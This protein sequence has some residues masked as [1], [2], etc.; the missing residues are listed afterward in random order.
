MNIKYYPNDGTVINEYNISK[1]IGN[2][3]NMEEKLNLENKIEMYENIIKDY[4]KK[5]KIK[6]DKQ[7]IK[8]F[9][10]IIFTITNLIIIGKSILLFLNYGLTTN[11]L[12]KSIIILIF[13]I[14]SALNIEEIK[15]EKSI[16]LLT[17][18]LTILK[19]NLNITKE[20]LNNLSLE[21]NLHQD[22]K[23]I[24]LISG[25]I[26]E[27]DIKKEMNDTYKNHYEEIKRTRT[28]NKQ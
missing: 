3:F 20:K 10:I 15:K 19:H 1:N 8:K 12:S 18:E 5:I 4:E 13:T 28:K 11:L 21:K 7:F 27:E 16:V 26:L 23:P 2:S 9:L 25:R 6:K 22:N 17:Q 14:F 24:F